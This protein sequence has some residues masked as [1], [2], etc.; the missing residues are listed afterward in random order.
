M[1]ELRR[2]GC[3]M[4]EPDRPFTLSGREIAVVRTVIATRRR[5][6]ELLQDAQA[7]GDYSTETKCR[8]LLFKI[9]HDED[10]RELMQFYGLSW[11]S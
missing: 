8:A 6:V 5:C 9:E 10:M 3:E 11:E 7:R 2:K 4:A 1:V